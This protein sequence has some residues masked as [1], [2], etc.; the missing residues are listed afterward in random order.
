MRGE[1]DPETMI[2]LLVVAALALFVGFF[3][4]VL[5]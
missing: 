5:L 1:S 3:V 2:A 4:A